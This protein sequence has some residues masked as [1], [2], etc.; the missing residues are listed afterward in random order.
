MGRLGISFIADKSLREYGELGS[1]I[2]RYDF[3]TISV[4]EDLL[5]QP[6]WPAL[7]QFAL[8]TKRPRLGPA[9]VNPYL[10]HPVPTAANVAL[11]DEVSQ[12]R[13]YLGV[14]KGGFFDNIRVRQPRPQTAIREMVEVVQMLLS[15]EHQPYEGTFFQVGPQ[16]SLRVPIPRRRVPIMIGTWGENTAG[17]AGRIADMMKVGGCANPDS[18]PVFRSYI[19][20]GAKTVGRDPSEIRLFFGA[21]TVVDRDRRVAEAVARRR[22]AMYV[23]AIGRLDPTFAPAPDEIDSVEKAMAVGD[24]EGAARVM[25]EDTMRR[26]SCFGTPA[27]IIRQ[28]EGLFDAGVDVFEL[29]SPHGNDEAEAIRLL[30]EEVLPAFK[31]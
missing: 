7:F 13:A 8:H 30:G 2:D 12:G 19:A 4:Y 10:N 9:V 17:L 5:Y 18:A 25:S 3:E 6:P 15:G 1:L 21:T 28:M 11:L 23:A 31:S 16:A 20:A 14:G 27:D 22:V 26:F 29:G 24:V